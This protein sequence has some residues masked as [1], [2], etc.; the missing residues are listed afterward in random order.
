MK[1]GVCFSIFQ[2]HLRKCGAKVSYSNYNKVLYLDN[3]K[4]FCIERSTFLMDFSQCQH[5]L[6]VELGSGTFSKLN[7]LFTRSTALSFKATL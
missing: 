7:K 2:S 1:L 3:Y 5:I 4:M 6:E